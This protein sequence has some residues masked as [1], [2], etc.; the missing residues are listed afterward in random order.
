[1]LDETDFTLPGP[2]EDGGYKLAFTRYRPEYASA[3]IDARQHSQLSLV[4]LHSVASHKET[5]KPTVEHLFQLQ[6][7]A[8]NKAFAVLEVWAMDSPNH[9]RAGVLNA[10]LFK[11]R[12][13][14]VSGIQ[15]ARAV[16]VLLQSDL[17]AGNRTVAIGHSAGACVMI[18][19]TEGYPLHELP[20][21]SFILVEP[22]MMTREI[23]R[24]ALEQDTVL[25][26]A[27]EVARGRKDIWPSRAAAREWFPKRLPWRRWD[28]RVLDLYVEY[29]LCDLPTPT[30]PDRTLGVTLATTR[31]QEISGYSGHE[32]GFAGLERLVLLCATI[33]VHTIFA[34][35]ND[36]V[37]EETKQA[38]VSESAGRRMKSMTTV[39][40]AGHLVVQENP[41]G[42]A[43]AIW[44]ILHI[45]YAPLACRL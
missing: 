20:Y 5:W 24:R 44:G 31:T 37:P 2:T 43:L 8:P 16:Q 25:L 45:D 18:Q 36:M 26:R 39:A 10:A 41:R 19:S 11:D 34:S 7:T 17:L 21:S 28:A 38:I 1:M 6:T 23:Y 13:E 12:P 40:D 15:W 9:A 22:T 29:A 14:G 3:P 33:P 4:V 27:I 42:L 32:D 35:N 30:Y